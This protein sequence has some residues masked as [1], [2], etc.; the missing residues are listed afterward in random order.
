MMSL[1]AFVL[2][3]IANDFE[4][5]LENENDIQYVHRWVWENTDSAS[6]GLDRSRQMNL[7][8]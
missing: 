5:D 1:N 8:R 4:I 2:E 6:N 7:I 3:R